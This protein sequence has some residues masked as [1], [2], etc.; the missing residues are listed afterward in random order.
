M[1]PPPLQLGIRVT[2]SLCIKAVHYRQSTNFSNGPRVRVCGYSNKDSVIT[3]SFISGCFIVKDNGTLTP[4]LSNITI[5]FQQLYSDTQK[6]FSEFY[7]VTTETYEP[8]ICINCTETY[9]NVNK[10]Y[11]DLKAD[12][13]EGIVCMDIV[14]AV[15]IYLV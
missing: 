7:D 9:C 2:T 13:G 12:T 8:S 10:Y 6:C 4:Q 11:E 15:S 1:L 5:K 3:I 14:D